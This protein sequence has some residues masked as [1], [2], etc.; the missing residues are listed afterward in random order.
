MSRRAGR[1]AGLLDWERQEP[2]GA[3]GTDRLQLT[4]QLRLDPHPVLG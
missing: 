2:E 1:T 4:L 3:P